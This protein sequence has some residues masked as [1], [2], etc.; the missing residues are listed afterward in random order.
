MPAL[1]FLAWVGLSLVA[2]LFVADATLD[3]TGPVLITS[4]RIGLP[5]PW[6]PDTTQTSDA[7]PALAPAATP[8]VQLAAQPE[9]EP[10]PEPKPEPAARTI[11]AT[12]LKARAEA[13]L[14]K[15]RIAREPIDG[16]RNHPQQNGLADRFSIRD[17]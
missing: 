17:Q 5:E 16:Q 8:Q 13:P 4:S 15:N 6:H 9:P 11:N 1:A 10:E 14:E 2:L 7:A 12:A 3:D